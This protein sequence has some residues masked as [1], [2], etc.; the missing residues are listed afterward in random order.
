MRWKELWFLYLILKYISVD[1]FNKADKNLFK[2][3]NAY[4]KR[5]Q[6]YSTYTT[7][8]YTIMPTLLGTSQ[9]ADWISL[10]VVTTNT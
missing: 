4:I 7:P 6:I 8:F 3:R 10:H 1:I 2:F 5:Q 9:D